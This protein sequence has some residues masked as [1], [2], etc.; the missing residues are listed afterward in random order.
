MAPSW[1]ARIGD[2]EVV[3]DTA[4]R[5]ARKKADRDNMRGFAGRT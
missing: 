1:V 2:T 3:A 5:T 4:R